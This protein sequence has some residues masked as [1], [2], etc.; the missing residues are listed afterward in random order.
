M[1]GHTPEECTPTGANPQA[2]VPRDNPVP[3]NHCAT[4]P[5]PKE[6]PTNVRTGYIGGLRP[7]RLRRVIMREVP[8]GR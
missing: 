4:R 3:K 1:R 5:Q 6:W 2:F 8:R 7:Y